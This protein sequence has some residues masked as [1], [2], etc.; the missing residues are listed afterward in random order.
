M[1]KI[2]GSSLFLIFMLASL[3]LGCNDNKEKEM[4]EKQ[5]V[6][7]FFH[8]IYNEKDIDKAIS[9]SSTDFKKEIEKYHT[10]HNVA[11]RLFNMSFD[12]VS[13]HTSAKKRQ[14]LDDYTIQVTMMVQFTGKRDGNSYKDYKKIGLIKDNNQWL[15]NELMED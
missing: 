9:L 15:I 7:S 2:K 4:S 5:V 12:S 8:A 11:R 3:L 1:D 6:T 13:L 14:I 10:A